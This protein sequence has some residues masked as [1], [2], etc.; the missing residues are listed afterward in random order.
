MYAYRSAMYTPQI[1]VDGCMCAS[2]VYASILEFLD[3]EDA[4]HTK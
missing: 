1:F 4:V 2:V 3:A